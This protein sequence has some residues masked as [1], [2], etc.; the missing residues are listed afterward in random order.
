MKMKEV[1]YKKYSTNSLLV[2][3]D[4]LKQEEQRLLKEYHCKDIDEVLIKQK[5]ILE[6][7]NE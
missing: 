2:V 5:K 7:K 6:D 4:I 1:D 3:S